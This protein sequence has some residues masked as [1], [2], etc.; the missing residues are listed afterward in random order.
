[1]KIRK[2]LA[3]FSALFAIIL[4]LVLTPNWLNLPCSVLSAQ[5]LA[6]TTE[7]I[8]ITGSTQDERIA[9]M[10]AAFNIVFTNH[11]NE[12]ILY[13][14]YEECD[15]ILSTYYRQLNKHA[16]D[17][18]NGILECDYIH[19]EY[20]NNLSQYVMYWSFTWK[21]SETETSSVYTHAQTFLNSSSYKALT[22]DD[23]R[24]SAI[25]E[26]IATSFVYDTDLNNY[27]AY[28][29][30]TTGKGVCQA[31][32]QYGYAILS[33]AGYNVQIICPRQF[34]NAEDKTHIEYYCKGFTGANHGWNLVQVGGNW[35]HM[36]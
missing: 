17:Y 25:N 21:E 13:V 15:L 10:Q 11:L 20:D 9:S 7:T 27:T 19:A 36:E 5:V 29:M 6:N 8:E 1:M 33:L 30:I 4:G 28:S 3:K 23:E 35:Y 26:F 22:T 24:L 14:N 32:S 12:L 34:Y 31:Y 18:I 2:R 16:N